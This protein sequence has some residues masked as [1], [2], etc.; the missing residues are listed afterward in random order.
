[1]ENN[2]DEAGFSNHIYHAYLEGNCLFLMAFSIP[3]SSSMSD[4]FLINID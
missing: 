2:V 1:M 3:E 4:T